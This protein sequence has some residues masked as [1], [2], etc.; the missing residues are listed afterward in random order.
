MSQG[1]Q[2]G[3]EN[4]A[5]DYSRGSTANCVLSFPVQHYPCM[6]MGGWELGQVAPD[7]LL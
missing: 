5:R 1:Q 3:K 2:S 7:T 4:T 6:I